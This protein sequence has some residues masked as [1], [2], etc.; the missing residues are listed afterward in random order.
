MLVCG[1]LRRGSVNTAVL[2]TVR[3][4][5]PPA[6]HPHLYQGLGGLPHFNPDDDNETVDSRVADLR[7][8][9]AA[10]DAVLFSTPEY[11]GELPGSFKNLLDWTVGGGLYRKP[12]GW[13]NSSPLGAADTY[14]SLRRVLGYVNADIVE[15]ACADIPVLRTDIEEGSVKTERPRAEITAVVAALIR[16]V[17]A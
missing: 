3:Q 11:A 1:S 10:A 5:A 15:A 13:I 9:L 2:E 8:Q 14:A 12:V 16:H 4:V 17:A 7:G 6:V